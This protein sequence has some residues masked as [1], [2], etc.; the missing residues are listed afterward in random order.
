MN[1]LDKK[2][3]NIIDSNIEKSTDKYSEDV[4]KDISEKYK[5]EF[6]DDYVYYLMK[7]GNDYI[8]DGYKLVP[9]FDENVQIEIDSIFGLYMDENCLIDKLE[10]YKDILPNNLFPIADVAGGDLIC[11]G[12]S[13]DKKNKVYLWK[14]D[15]NVENILL[16]ANSFYDFIMRIIFVKE[17][18]IDYS[19]VKIQLS[20]RLLD[21]FSKPK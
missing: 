1:Q 12:K 5:I 9:N 6:E 4:I 21:L 16:L 2:L 15:K 17:K 11:L 3:Q 14:H 8:K 19:K 20:D 18:Q 7:Y 13:E 10:D